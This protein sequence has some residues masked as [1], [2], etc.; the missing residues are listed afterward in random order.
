[1]EAYQQLEKEWAEYVGADP[2]HAVAC[3]SGTSALHLALEALEL[4]KGGEVIVPDF[5][6]VACARA[7]VMAGLRPVFADCN[8]RLVIDRSSVEKLITA[9][10]VA[11][12]PVHI[13]GRG[14]PMKEIADLASTHGLFI[15]EDC[16]EYHGAPL[17]GYA[18]AY[19]WSFYKNKIVA[20][21]EGGMVVFGNSDGGDE[22]A[23]LARMLR[24]QGFTD[25][26]DFWHVPRGFNARMPNAQAQLIRESLKRIDENL[27][28][29]RHL[30]EW[31]DRLLPDKFRA[32][33]REAPWVYDLWDVPDA[34]DKVH[35]LNKRGIPARMAFKPMSAQPEF[36][37]A[38]F[39]R[40]EA[41]RRS[42]STLYLPLIPK[43]DMRSVASV[44]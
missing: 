35:K 12:M 14:C 37:D 33:P 9:R 41:W 43:V 25:E 6:M 17:S 15:V 1:M 13:Y 27:A 34:C 39:N 42:M 20:G 3:N 16:A 29:R 8:N 4:P 11:I 30:V 21:E 10:T 23:R 19:C 28:R 40:L 44:L 7:V 24:C 5:T 18:D 38:R 31:F 32:A 2:Y 26:H 22:Q 36:Y